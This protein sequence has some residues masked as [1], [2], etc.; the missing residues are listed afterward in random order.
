MKTP[1]FSKKKAR[2]LLYCILL[3]TGLTYCTVKN[4]YI[5]NDTHGVSVIPGPGPYK[6]AI[7]YIINLDRSKER[8]AYIKPLVD[9]LGLPVERI[10][11]VEGKLLSDEYVNKNVDQETYLAASPHIPTKG[12]IG[13]TLS[14]MKAWKTLLESNFEYA[15]IFEDDVGFDPI[16]LRSAI[17]QLVSN[18]T[19]WDLNM[20]AISAG[21]VWLPI[22]SL[23]QGQ[24]LS[25]YLTRGWCAAAY[26]INRKAATKLLAKT[27]PITTSLDFYYTR[28]WEFDL[29]LTGIERPRLAQ[30]TYEGVSEI[31]DRPKSHGFICAV[32][33]TLVL[34]STHVMWFL[35]NLK[36][37]IKSVL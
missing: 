15:I 20:F 28:A 24:K 21:K 32:K 18:N 23:Q 29:K 26:M 19:L 6:G 16:K 3:L 14:H 4:G 33:H 22:K 37:Y 9:Q 35:Y 27:W 12:A 17:D 36:C 8:W 1:H 25:I 2:I 30:P 7:T 34:Y 31:G 10:S 13:C 5:L 11:G